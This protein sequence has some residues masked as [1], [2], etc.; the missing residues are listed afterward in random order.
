MMTS[1]DL[2]G[3]PTKIIN[4]DKINIILGKNGSGKSSFLRTMTQALR[5]RDDFY[6]RY[7]SPERAGSFR[8]EGGIMTN[9]ANDANWLENSRI[10]NQSANFKAAS[11]VLLGEVE[12]LYRRRMESDPS[13][14]INLNRNFLTDR[15]ERINA[16]LSNVA[17]RQT[18]SSFEFVNSSGIVVNPEQLSSGESEAVSLAVEIL[19]FFEAIEDGKFSVLLLD[20]PD[21]HLHPDLQARLG[22]L[23]ITLLN[24]QHQNNGEI[25]IVIATHSTPLACSLITS[26][27][28]S[29]G[30]KVFGSDEVLMKKASV[31]LA[32]IA[33]F[34]GHPLSLALSDDVALIVEG[35]DDERVWQQAARSS[36][37]RVRLFPVLA[38]SVEKMVELETVSSELMSAL[39]DDPLVFSLRD[40][41]GVKGSRLDHAPPLF[42]YRLDCYA[43]ENLLVTDQCLSIMGVENWTDFVSAGRAWLSENSTHKDINLVSRLIESDA[44][45]RLRHEK[46]KAIRNIICAICA[47]RKPWEVVVGQALGSIT[48]VDKDAGLQIVDFFGREGF[49]A[50]IFREFPR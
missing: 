32:R 1:K 23:L 25:A 22:R 12:M 18:K 41:D 3:A 37:G 44:A 17:L 40:G 13:I 11:A 20:E 47:V 16:M 49:L 45:D 39:Y 10:V 14:R 46:I 26:P 4:V 33:P 19:Y 34:F 6:V 2:E 31:A 35:E 30:T 7:I 15:I 27:V 43:I 8:R 28:A 9:I 50:L 36:D 29:V 48:A 24:E 5:G 21:V 42:R 38:S